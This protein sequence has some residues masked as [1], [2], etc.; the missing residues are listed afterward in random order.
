[1]NS[2]TSDGVRIAYQVDGPDDAPPLVLINSIGSNLHMWA[3]QVELLRNKFRIVRY[4]TRGHGLSDAPTGSYTL[5]QLGLDLLGLLDE[6]QIEQANIC[7]LSLG[8]ITA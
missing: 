2:V 4:D 1:M 8:G 3:A 5:D 6:L 7:G